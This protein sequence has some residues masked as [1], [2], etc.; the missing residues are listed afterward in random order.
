MADI[1]PL[2][3]RNEHFAINKKHEGVPVYP[4]GSACIISCLDPR[5]DP[6]EF[7]ELRAGEAIVIRNAGGRVTQAVIADIAL[8]AYLSET[9]LK[10]EGRL[11]EVAVIHH[12]K[13][14]TRFLAD[15]EFRQEFAARI[16]ADEANLAEEAV[17]DPVRTVHH[18]VEMLR[19]SPLLSRKIAFSG[20]VYDVD[21]GV[22]TTIIPTTLSHLL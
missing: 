4:S 2:L 8:A 6:R 13:C 22:V 18:D 12:N 1:D 21:T 3:A 19:S 16:R 9:V 20:H 11:F 10:P 7:L 14:G 15:A 17:V 5:T